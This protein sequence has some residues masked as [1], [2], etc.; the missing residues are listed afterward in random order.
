MSS[1]LLVIIV[2]ASGVG[3]FVGYRYIKLKRADGASIQIIKDLEERQTSI[4]SANGQQLISVTF[5]TQL[6]NSQTN[7]Y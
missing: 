1:V 4:T 7:V 2:F 6:T 3:C 5:P